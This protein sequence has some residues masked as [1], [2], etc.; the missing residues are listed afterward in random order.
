MGALFEVPVNPILLVYSL[1]SR[2]GKWLLGR[3]RSTATA[4]EIKGPAASLAKLT[5]QPVETELAAA[6]AEKPRTAARA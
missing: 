3:W 5:R 6:D 2:R 1:K 4:A